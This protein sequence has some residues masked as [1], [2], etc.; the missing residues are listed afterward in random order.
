MKHLWF[1][2][3]PVLISTDAQTNVFMFFGNEPYTDIVASSSTVTCPTVAV[4]SCA[5]LQGDSTDC[6]FSCMNPNGT[7]SKSTW[8][9]CPK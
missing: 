8:M 2:I 1:I 9:P 5:V 3:L 7:L 6:Y 4:S